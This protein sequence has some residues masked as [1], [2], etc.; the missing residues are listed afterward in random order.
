MPGSA[1][2]QRADCLTGCRQ[3]LKRAIS[4]TEAAEILFS[5]DKKQ[6]AYALS[7]LAMDECGKFFLIAKAY[8]SST[9][10]PVVVVGFA[11]HNAKYD[12]VLDYCI[13]A[14]GSP[15]MK[16]M[17]E[18]SKNPAFDLSNVAKLSYESIR[19]GSIT[20]EAATL[21]GAPPLKYRNK[22]FYIDYDGAWQD[23]RYPGDEVCAAQIKLVK[24]AAKSYLYVLNRDNAVPSIQ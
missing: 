8:H 6:E 15:T 5:I 18:I 22:A 1:T 11:D 16:L 2:I 12:E 19:N 14:A 4:Y 10:D 20:R 3:A 7:F 17:E 13:K 24:G 9:S 23:P 21:K